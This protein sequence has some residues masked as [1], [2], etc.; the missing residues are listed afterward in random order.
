MVKNK[1]R[2][3]KMQGT[4]LYQCGSAD[5]YV[6]GDSKMG[7]MVMVSER[8]KMGRMLPTRHKT[9]NAAIKAAKAFVKKKGE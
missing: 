6:S 5:A 2:I 4:K 8:N 1:L 9:K 7:Y 3:I